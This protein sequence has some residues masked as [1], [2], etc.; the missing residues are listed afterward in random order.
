MSDY[1][2]DN[3]IEKPQAIVVCAA[4]RYCDLLICGARHWDEVMRNQ[5]EALTNLGSEIKAG[6]FEQGFINQ[7]GEFLTREEAVPVAKESGQRLRAD[8][9]KI[10]GALFSEDL[11]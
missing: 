6:N 2:K 7:F 4:C 11:Y 3:G 8:K 5:L 10:G 9:D 1:W